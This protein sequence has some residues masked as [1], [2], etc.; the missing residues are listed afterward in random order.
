M[1]AWLSSIGESIGIFV[2][3]ISSLLSGI[4]SVFALVGQSFVFLGTAWAAMPSVLQVFVPAGIC[5][6]IVFL[7]IGR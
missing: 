6:S 3:F 1:F 5:I 2:Q 7:L 4:L